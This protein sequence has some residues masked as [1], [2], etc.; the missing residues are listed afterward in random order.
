MADYCTRSDIEDLFGSVNVV[1]WAD[2]DNGQDADTI[3]ARIARA[4]AVCSARIDDR[5]R[6]GPYT[7]PILGDPA[8]LVN[9]CASL[10]GVWLYESRGVQDYSP[11]GG[12]PVHRLRWFSEQAEK[13]LRDL[14][15]GV[16]RLDAALQG[17]GTTAPMVVKGLRR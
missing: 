2:M 17:Y 6:G 8:T 1:Q 12:F 7:L 13:T 15:S 10:A 9:L 14:R 4:I 16:L 5:L 11:E 3:T